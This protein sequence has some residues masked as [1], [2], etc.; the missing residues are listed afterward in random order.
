MGRQRHHNLGHLFPCFIQYAGG[1]GYS[2]EEHIELLVQ[3]SGHPLSMYSP[4]NDRLAKEEAPDVL[5]CM[6]I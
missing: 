6:A 2:R 4:I 3:I 1:I 5:I